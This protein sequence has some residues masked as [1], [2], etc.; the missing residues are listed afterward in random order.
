M[1]AH[2]GFAQPR[3]LFSA[4][5]SKILVVLGGTTRLKSMFTRDFM[6]RDFLAVQNRIPSFI[7]SPFWKNIPA[8]RSPFFLWGTFSYIFFFLPHGNAAP[9]KRETFQNTDLPFLWRPIFYFRF[10]KS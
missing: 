8:D 10:F 2:I 3:T 5:A 1:P 9:S 7:P 6:T 4:K